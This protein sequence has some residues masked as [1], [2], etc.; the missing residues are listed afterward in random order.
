MSNGRGES[1]FRVAVQRPRMQRVRSV[2]GHWASLI[3]SVCLRNQQFP[4]ALLRRQRI[5]VSVQSDT[6]RPRA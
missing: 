1:C 3:V 2:V 4:P 5:T 6:Y